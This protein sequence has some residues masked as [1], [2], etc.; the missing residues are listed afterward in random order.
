MAIGLMHG[1][2]AFVKKAYVMQ[3][4]GSAWWS[5]DHFDA[6]YAALIHH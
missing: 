5:D 4:Q 3:L 2:A 6:S 1:G